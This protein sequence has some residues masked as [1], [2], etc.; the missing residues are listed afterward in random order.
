LTLA[1]QMGGDGR[2]PREG[3]MR[4]MAG[5]ITGAV[6]IPLLH[7]ADGTA[8]EVKAQ[9]IRNVGLLVTLGKAPS[10]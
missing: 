10:K 6:S 4:M 9:G 7:I 5:A 2:T 3:A 8:E 1:R